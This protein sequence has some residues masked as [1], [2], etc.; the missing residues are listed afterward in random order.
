MPQAF[1]NCQKAGG[2]IRTITLKGDRYMRI[3][4]LDGKSHASE[5]K[6]SKGKK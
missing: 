1:D 3:C 6:E 2:R 4:Y 5:V